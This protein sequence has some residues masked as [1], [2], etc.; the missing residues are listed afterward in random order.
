MDQMGKTKVLKQLAIVA[1]RGVKGVGT[2]ASAER[3]ELITVTVAVSAQGIFVFPA[4]FFP[5]KMFVITSHDI[6]QQVVLKTPRDL[7]GLMKS[8]LSKPLNTS[9]AMLNLPK[10]L[11]RSSWKTIHPT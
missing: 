7:A 4:L 10:I 3:G 11:C 1:G 5:R 9:F 2:V 6:A 8:T